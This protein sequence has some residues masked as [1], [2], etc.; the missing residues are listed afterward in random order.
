M[1]LSHGINKFY[2][3]RFET[4]FD[5][6][7]D[8]NFFVDVETFV[9]MFAQAGNE[10]INSLIEFRVDE[11]QRRVKDETTSRDQFIR[12]KYVNKRFINHD[13]LDLTKNYMD[14][15]NRLLNTAAS[16]R[17]LPMTIYY[18]FLGAC[19]TAR[20]AGRTALENSNMYQSIYLFLQVTFLK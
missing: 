16:G 17:S 9:A 7:C 8:E 12:D 4:L 3:I 10:T 6:L 11:A 20:V 14:D 19:L 5:D 13:E 1:K 2:L 18:V 15:L